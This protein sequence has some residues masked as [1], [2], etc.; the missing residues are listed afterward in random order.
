MRRKHHDDKFIVRYPE[1]EC[2]LRGRWES[3]ARGGENPPPLVTGGLLLP[4]A[5]ATIAASGRY[6]LNP[7][8][9]SSSI[10]RP[11]HRRLIVPALTGLAMLATANGAPAQDGDGFEAVEDPAAELFALPEPWSPLRS[12]NE[13][14]EGLLNAVVTLDHQVPIAGDE[15]LHV[16]EFLTLRSWL[17]WPKRAVL[18]L[19]GTALTADHWAIPVAGYNGPEMAARRGMFAFTVD[20]IG[21]GDHYRAGADALDST[22]ERN[23]EA[24]KAVVRYIRHFRAVPAVDIVGESWGGA[25]ATQLGADPESVRSCVMA[26]VTYKTMS[27]PIFVSPQFVA[28][29]KSLENNYLPADPAVIEPLMAEAPEGVKS[30]VREKLSGPFLTTQLWQ[31]IGGLPHFDPGAAKVPGLVISG[32]TESDDGRALAADYGSDGARF[33]EIENAHH[34]PRLESPEIASTFWSQVFQ[35]IDGPAD[36]E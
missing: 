8:E 20:Y 28:F 21:V 9:S 15:T 30:Y 29:L 27:N 16:R 1:N 12:E 34:S 35:F 5:G 10:C 3:R 25:F 11:W 23:L 18:F 6:D 24:M 7:G 14:P 32:G 22:F 33:F 31:I 4:A 36:R 2:Q 13:D 26:S 19:G 17:R